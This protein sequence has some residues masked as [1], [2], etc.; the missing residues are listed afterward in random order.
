MFILAGIGCVHAEDDLVNQKLIEISAKKCRNDE[1]IYFGTQYPVA[2]K[3]LYQQGIVPIVLSFANK[4]NQPW[5]FCVQ[6]FENK[7]VTNFWRIYEIKYAYPASILA[8][9]L[10]SFA[11]AVAVAQSINDQTLKPWQAGAIKLTLK[12]YNCGCSGAIRKYLAK[13]LFNKFL[14]GG[15]LASFANMLYQ[16]AKERSEF[17]QQF[18]WFTQNGWHQGD[19]V[20]SKEKQKKYIFLDKNKMDLA[21]LRICFKSQSGQKIIQEVFIEG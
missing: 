17:K 7:Y 2:A 12:S 9:M 3:E 15:W 11:N 10:G 19:T 20:Q 14:F 18:N 13:N 4:D 21:P 1:Q 6:D 5:F 16:G 8:M